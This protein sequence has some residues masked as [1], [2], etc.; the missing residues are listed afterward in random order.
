M[1]LLTIQSLSNE[2]L[3]MICLQLDAETY[4]YLVN[5]GLGQILSKKDHIKIGVFCKS[6]TISWHCKSILSGYGKSGTADA[7]TGSMTLPGSLA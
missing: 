5:A 6:V 2:L 1:K 4:H 7:L 3:Y